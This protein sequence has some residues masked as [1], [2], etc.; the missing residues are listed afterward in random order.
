MA[1]KTEY[2]PKKHYA[3]ITS[4]EKIPS[5]PLKGNWNMFY[6]D[7]RTFCEDEL[8]IFRKTHKYVEGQF[9]RLLPSGKDG[10]WKKPGRLLSTKEIKDFKARQ[11]VVAQEYD[12]LLT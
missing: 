12:D 8:V 2:V 10:Q 9:V 4:I 7:G 5:G 11:Q 1:N 3:E 6:I